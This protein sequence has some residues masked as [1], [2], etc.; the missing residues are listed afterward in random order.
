VV[1]PQ[2]WKTVQK[3]R[4]HDAQ[5]LGD[6]V[7]CRKQDEQANIGECYE[8]HFSL[9]EDV[10]CGVEMALLPPRAVLA[11]VLDQGLD[12]G[13]GIQEDVHRP[14]KQLVHDEGRQA[15]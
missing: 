9:R 1:H 11:V 5:R 6:L 7:Q 13:S 3:T 12:A 2:I 8:G 15:E 14:S 4:V 10:G